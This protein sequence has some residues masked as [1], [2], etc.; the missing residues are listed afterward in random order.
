[1]GLAARAGQPTPGR[2]RPIEAYSA[3]ASLN[4]EPEDRTADLGQEAG[5]KEGATPA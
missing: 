4:C 2:L 1:M 3:T 5:A